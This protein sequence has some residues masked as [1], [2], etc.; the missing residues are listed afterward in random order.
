VTAPAAPA[1]TGSRSTR[2]LGALALAGLALL[3]LFA[4]VWTPPEEDQRDAV[5]LVYIHVPIALWMYGGCLVAALGSFMWLRRRTRGWDILAAAGAELALLFSVLTLVTGAIYGR[6]T[7]G[8]YWTWDARLTSTALLALLLA[9]YHALRRLPSDV[10]TRARRSAVLGLLLVPNALLVH[11]SVDWWESLHETATISTLDPE[12]DGEMAFT[13]YLGVVVI[14]LVFAWLLIH[15]F[16]VGW[17]EERAERGQLD[18]ALEE[19][20]AEVVS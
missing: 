5:R 11:Y 15:R 20:R 9:G 1:H 3:V 7:W 4:F 16:R 8:T 17:L 19:R 18:V 2:V 13:I 10:D 14:G 12:I 6:P